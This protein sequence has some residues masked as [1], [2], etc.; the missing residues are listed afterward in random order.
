MCCHVR[1]ASFSRRRRPQRRPSSPMPPLAVLDLSKAGERRAHDFLCRMTSK[2]DH[3]WDLLS[4]RR[5]GDA[6]LCVVRWVYPSDAAKPFS[7]AEV[8]LTQTAVHWRSFASAEDARAAME[9]RSTAPAS[10]QG[11]V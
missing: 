3:R 6:L 5:H 9:R 10:S 2:S 11:A 1:S 4:L 8:S 7:L